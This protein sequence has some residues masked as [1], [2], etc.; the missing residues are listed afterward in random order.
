MKTVCITKIENDLRGRPQLH[1]A[2]ED[3]THL[4]VLPVSFTD[5]RAIQ[6]LLDQANGVEPQER[7]T[8]QNLPTT[9]APGGTRG[10]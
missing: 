5:A 1:L 8:S 3:G 7:P 4:G 2:S 10:R 6:R 9:A